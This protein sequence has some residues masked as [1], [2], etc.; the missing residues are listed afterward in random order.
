MKNLI[1]NNYNIDNDSTSYDLDDK[2]QHY[3][4]L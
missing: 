4:L 1:N 3:I 2:L